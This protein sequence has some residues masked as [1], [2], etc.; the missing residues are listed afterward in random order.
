MSKRAK[1]KRTAWNQR[2]RST[3]S[4]FKERTDVWLSTF[5]DTYQDIVPNVCEIVLQTT[6][7]MLCGYMAHTIVAL[8][9]ERLCPVRGVLV[10]RQ[11]EGQAPKEGGYMGHW[12]CEDK[13]GEIVDFAPLNPDLLW[14]YV[15]VSDS[16]QKYFDLSE[17]TLQP[18]N[19][20]VRQWHEDFDALRHTEHFG[21]TI[22]RLVE[23]SR[24]MAARLT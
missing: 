21:Q 15:P 1:K 23:I 14:E 11:F 8:S 17:L 18:M 13:Y 22:Q 20:T 6:A 9:N 24:S 10:G 4:A 7:G 16:N 19:K 12:W 2:R 5:T 3:S